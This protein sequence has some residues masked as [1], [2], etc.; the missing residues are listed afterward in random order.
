MGVAPPLVG[1]DHK[2]A[3]AGKM[4]R[5]GNLTFDEVGETWMMRMRMRMMMIRRRRRR[6]MMKFVLDSFPVR[7]RVPWCGRWC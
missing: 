6:M 3:L 5:A 4:Q 1:E 2:R 7:P